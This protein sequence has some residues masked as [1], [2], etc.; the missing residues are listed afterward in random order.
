MFIETVRTDKLTEPLS[1]R[2]LPELLVKIL[3]LELQVTINRLLLELVTTLSPEPQPNNLLLLELKELRG[4]LTT[5][6]D[7]VTL[8]LELLL[9]VSI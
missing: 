2:L 4:L 8:T 3:T 1:I 5:H 7:M 9:L 6:R